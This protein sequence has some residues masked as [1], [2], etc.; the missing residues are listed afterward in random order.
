M[1]L[2]A[3]CQ[4]VPGSQLLI[5]LLQAVLGVGNYLN[6]GTFKGNAP[7]LALPFTTMSVLLSFG[8]KIGPPHS[9]SP[10]EML[11]STAWK[12]GAAKLHACIGE[13][14]LQSF[15]LSSCLHKQC[16]HLSTQFLI[17]CFLCN[18]STIFSLHSWHDK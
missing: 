18:R 14:R 15:T 9:S 7:G 8:T 17:E 12:P 5:Q 1:L 4:E 6:Q 10:Q 11:A 3:A 16:L 2:Q 13:Q